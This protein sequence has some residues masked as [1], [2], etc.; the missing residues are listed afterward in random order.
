MLTAL[1]VVFLYLGSIIE[2]ADISMAVIASVFCVLAVIEYGGGAPWIVFSVT[3]VLSLVLVP[4]KSPAV[5]YT[6]FFGYYPI[7]KERFEKMRTA[8]SWICKEAVFNVALAAIAVCLKF[9]LLTYTDIP[10]AVFAV[11]AV[12]CEAV[13]VLYDIALSRLIS[14]YVYRLRKRLKIK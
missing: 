11:F 8:V 10:L 12:L 1:G 3:A 7:L 14:F 4:Q 2:I 6:L 13:F 5:M 9:G